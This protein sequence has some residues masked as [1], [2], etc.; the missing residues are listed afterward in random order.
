METGLNPSQTLHAYGRSGVDVG[1]LRS[2]AHRAGAGWALEASRTPQAARTS[3]GDSWSGAR[4]FVGQR[5]LLRGSV[6]T[7]ASGSW[8]SSRSSDSASRVAVQRMAAVGGRTSGSY[9]ST[10]RISLRDG[11]SSER[12]RRARQSIGHARVGACGVS[13]AAASDRRRRPPRPARSIRRPS[14]DPR[15]GHRG[16]RSE[17][18]YAGRTYHPGLPQKISQNYGFLLTKTHETEAMARVSRWSSSL[19]GGNTVGGALSTRD[20]GRRTVRPGSLDVTAPVARR[21]AVG[22]GAVGSTLPR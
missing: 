1:G 20:R 12:N 5:R 2:P 11:R 9:R 21:C 4:G 19:P 7:V 22:G 13:R 16:G 10:R 18:T 3:R 14:S 6:P 17:L 15:R 8:P